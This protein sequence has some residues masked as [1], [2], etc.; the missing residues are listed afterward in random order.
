MTVQKTPAGLRAL[1]V[2]L[3]P[4]SPGAYIEVQVNTA[5]KKKAPRIMIKTLTLQQLL[6]RHC[7]TI[8][9]A[10]PTTT[11]NKQTTTHKQQQS[12]FQTQGRLD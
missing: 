10:T 12:T 7:A 1:T 6:Y 11:D 5:H 3:W 8:S 4:H 2:V 9:Q